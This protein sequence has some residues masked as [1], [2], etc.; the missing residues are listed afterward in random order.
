V[1]QFVWAEKRLV[2][3]LHGCQQVRENLPK[4]FTAAKAMHKT[5]PLEI[6]AEVKDKDA[7]TYKATF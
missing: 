6:S 1:W 3:K 4:K 2:F 5:P 7:S